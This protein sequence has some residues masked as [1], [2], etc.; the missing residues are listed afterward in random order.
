LH[1]AYV[2]LGGLGSL[3]LVGNAVPLTL[4]P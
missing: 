3:D 4:V 2:V 1:H